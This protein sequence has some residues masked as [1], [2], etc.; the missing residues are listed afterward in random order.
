MHRNGINVRYL[1][2][3][4]NIVTKSHVRKLLLHEMIARVVKS[5]V[6]R[7]LRHKVSET[8]APSEHPYRLLVI[9]YFNLVLGR[10]QDSPQYWSQ[11]LPALLKSKFQGMSCDH[12]LLDEID[13]ASL[14]DRIQQLTGVR[15]TARAFSEIKS[16]PFTIEL[17]TQDVEKVSCRVKDMNIMASSEAIMLYIQSLNCTGQQSERLFQLALSKFEDAQSLSPDN[18]VSLLDWANAIFHRAKVKRGQERLELIKQATRRFHSLNDHVHLYI[19]AKAIHQFASEETNSSE[20]QKLYEIA[21]EN[22]RLSLELKK[23]S[24]A[25]PNV[26]PRVTED[27]RLSLSDSSFNLSTFLNSNTNSDS[28]LELTP[29]TF[30]NSQYYHEWGNVLYDKAVLWAGTKQGAEL[31]KQAG[32]KYMKAYP[33]LVDDLD[34]DPI[35]FATLIRSRNDTHS[36]LDVSRVPS[37]SD[38][39]LKSQEVSSYESMKLSHSNFVSDYSFF[40]F[41][42]KLTSLDLSG[43]VLITGEILQLLSDKAPNLETLI[44]SGC[45]LGQNESSTQPLKGI[46]NEN[47]QNSENQKANSNAVKPPLPLAPQVSPSLFSSS[48]LKIFK[49]L[50]T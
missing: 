11:D 29:G 12:I 17:V 35:T 20:R 15:L 50:T 43:C 40:H 3:V 4:Y 10:S 18:N 30:K 38:S 47:L 16:S 39:F 2:A 28:K 45:K 1:G 21:S 6:F 42:P 5:Q 34:N 23:Q 32:R 41:Y 48:D 13:M 24:D 7:Q 33:E 36:V 46:S 31:F 25:N 14:F 26:V 49:L 8:K 22:Y 9:E 44:L 37:L 27:K 19:F